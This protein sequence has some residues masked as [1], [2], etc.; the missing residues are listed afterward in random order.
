M[1]LPPGLPDAHQ[2]R[3]P[4][5]GSGGRCRMQG[6]RWAGAFCF[7][8]RSAGSSALCGFLFLLVQL[9]LQQEHRNEC[10]NWQEGPDVFT[11]DLHH[12]EDAVVNG[13]KAQQGEGAAVEQLPLLVD[14]A[15]A[16][17]HRKRAHIFASFPI[18]SAQEVADL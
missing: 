6:S 11:A 4:A 8:G 15:D 7:F 9:S 16:E 13:R 3:S 5:C 1:N 10:H 12:V 18:S 14:E 17:A 2:Q